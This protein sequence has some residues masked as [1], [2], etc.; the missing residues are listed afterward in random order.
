MSVLSPVESAKRPGW[1]VLAMMY[2]W[3]GTQSPR[4]GLETHTWDGDVSSQVCLGLVICC[5]DVG[6]MELIDCRQK[7]LSPDDGG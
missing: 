7:H 5:F 6:N 4:A 2:A 1:V 3:S